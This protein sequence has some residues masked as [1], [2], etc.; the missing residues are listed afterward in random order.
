[1]PENCII[2]QS[3]KTYFKTII[4]IEKIATS[5]KNDNSV[6]KSFWLSFWSRAN[7][8]THSEF[9]SDSELIQN[10]TLNFLLIQRNSEDIDSE[11]CSDSEKFQNQYRNYSENVL[12]QYWKLKLFW[13]WSDSVLMLTEWKVR[14]YHGITQPVFLNYPIGH[15]I[16][17]RRLWSVIK[18]RIIVWIS[19]SDCVKILLRRICKKNLE[20]VAKDLATTDGCSLSILGSVRK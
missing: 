2:P 4:F 7:S 14:G 9:S 15:K 18:I 20:S 19:W 3:N 17:V 10:C 13:K 8:K 12:N 16:A 11:F 6:V 5:L 1:M